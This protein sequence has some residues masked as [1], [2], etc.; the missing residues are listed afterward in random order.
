MALL[1]GP[2]GGGV[3][4]NGIEFRCGPNGELTIPEGNQNIV[5]LLT[6]TH[7]FR[8]ATPEEQTKARNIDLQPEQ[9][10]RLVP[11]PKQPPEPAAKA[12][13]PIDPE[14]AERPEMFAWCKEHGVEVARNITT[15]KLRD[16]IKDVIAEA[17][18]PAA[19]A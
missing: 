14:T 19:K 13:E 5:S 16:V 18:A 10:Q 12:L 4:V 8:H 11:T 6:E 15:D 9:R 7:G 2:P 17:A 3:S 1:I